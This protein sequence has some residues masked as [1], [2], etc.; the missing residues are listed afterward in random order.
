MITAEDL[1]IELAHC[2]CSE[3][4]YQ[5]WLGI[6]YTEGVKTLAEKGECF[7]LL[8]AIASYQRVPT[9]QVQSQPPRIPALAVDRKR[10]P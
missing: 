1:Q 4:H 8:D 3:S 7:W 5:H 10:R 9:H 2:H 6:R